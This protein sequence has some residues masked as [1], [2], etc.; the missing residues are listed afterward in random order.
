MLASAFNARV[1][2]VA[3]AETFELASAFEGLFV[4]AFMTCLDYG[5][6]TK[7]APSN[8]AAGSSS[9]KATRE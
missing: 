2:R 1:R 6:L 7:N 9:A 5:G 4:E 3:D 8:A